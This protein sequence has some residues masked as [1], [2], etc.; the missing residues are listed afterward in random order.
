MRD[1]RAAALAVAEALA[2][3]STGDGERRTAAVRAGAAPAL[4]ALVQLSAVRES[5]VIF[6][7]CGAALALMTAQIQVD[8]A[9]RRVDAAAH[10]SAGIV[11]AIVSITSDPQRRLVVQEVRDIVDSF[12]QIF[13]ASSE[14]RHAALSAG[15][16]P[17]L[18]ALAAHPRLALGDGL[19]ACFVARAFASICRFE[20]GRRACIAT[21]GALS[22]LVSLAARPPV[23]RDEDAMQGLVMALELVI[24]QSEAGRA[25]AVA[26]GAVL[27]L[28][29]FVS[30]LVTASG[31][32]GWSAD[33][34]LSIA[35]ALS[36]AGA[37]PSGRDA[38]SSSPGAV[39]ALVALALHPSVQDDG[40]AFEGVA[41][42]LSRV[43][44]GSGG[45]CAWEAE[46]GAASLL[47]P[48]SAPGL[49]SLASHALVLGSARASQCVAYALAC[50][51]ES[52]EGHQAALSAGAVPALV[53]MACAE[54]ECVLIPALCGG[55]APPCWAS[56]A[57]RPA[58][59][60]ACRAALLRRSSP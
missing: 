47:P 55:W 26:S 20:E 5:A 59:P 34:A 43:A 35:A 6:R 60:R 10:K 42:A 18:V 14:G 46:D 50:L 9:A 21:P 24:C 45:L 53:S 33:I 29:S 3:L 51:C 58:W 36:S 8:A 30:R 2:L 25:A 56:R 1:S 57:R 38:I 39:L 41:T 19:A 11:S 7:N 52:D 17:A 16:V 4:A 28:V 37:S 44:S 31:W 27:A 23:A 54:A 12:R 32:A 40:A 49:V 22:S 15:M 48:R 13:A